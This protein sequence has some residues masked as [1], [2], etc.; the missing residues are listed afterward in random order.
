MKR[1][2]SWTLIAPA[3]LALAGLTACYDEA[4]TSSP[5]SDPVRTMGGDRP[6]TLTLPSDYEAGT[7]IPLVIVLHGFTSNAEWTDAYFGISRRIESDRIAVILPNGTRDSQERSF[8]NATDFCCNLQG[9]EV[10]DVAYL[11]GLVEEAAEHMAVDG[12]YLIGLSNGGFMSYRMAC[13]S[14]PELRA[15]A[16]VAGTTFQD[17]ARCEGA[18]P[19]S[20]LH[21]HGTADRTI[22]YAGGGR[23]GGARYPGAE[24]T[25]H[26]WA[27]RA[28]CEMEAA[29]AMPAMDLVEALPDDE[30]DV[31]RYDTGCDGGLRVELWT[32][33]DGGHVPGFDADDFGAR[34]VAWFAGAGG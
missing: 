20:I 6:A 29:E 7:P 21:I 24:E 3:V 25:V 27:A 23:E 9:S 14:M 34:V 11:N 28:G 30:T 8:W 13:E 16:S 5:V 10:D 4:E 2:R 22:R 31:T 12:V 32:V 33:E 18:R 1:L 15:I 26:R 17:P 19:I